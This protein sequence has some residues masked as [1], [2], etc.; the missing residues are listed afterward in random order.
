MHTTTTDPGDPSRPVT[1]LVIE[2]DD[3]TRAF[4]ADNLN[5]DGYE[6]IVAATARDA[7][8]LAGQHAPD[9]AILDLGLPDAGGLRVLDRIRSADHGSRLDPDL[10]VLIV[11]GQGSELDRV[12]GL[13]RGADDF[14]PKPFSYPELRARLGAVVRR[15]GRRK[16]AGRLRC[17]TLVLDPV[18]REVFL[19]DE[20][21]H[22][23]QK[24]FALLRELI[25]EPTRVVTKAELMRTIWGY[26]DGSASRTLD[27]HACRLRAKISTPQRR[28][29]VNVWGVGYRLMDGSGP[30]AA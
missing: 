30:G 5:A 23:S 7:V 21:V 4:L 1:V 20:P 22:L 2:D 18:A 11:S 10:P 19:D 14:L 29:V 9:A 27:S 17:G 12:R 24:E 28:F 26:S 15:S 25:A 8:R 16:R 6:P 3:A 13:E